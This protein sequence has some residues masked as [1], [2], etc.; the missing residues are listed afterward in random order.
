M[1]AKFRHKFRVTNRLRENFEGWA[2]MLPWILGTLLFFIVPI[3]QSF[4][5]S[6]GDLVR[7]VD[8]EVEFVG[9]V[10][11]RRIL[12]HDMSIVPGIISLAYY[13]LMNLPIV[14]V[15]SLFTA[16]L[17]NTDVKLR[18][19]WRACFILPVV[20][21]TGFVMNQLLGQNVVSGVEGATMELE[22]N[23][24]LTRGLAL[25]DEILLYLGPTV[26]RYITTFL[27]M[28]TS[29]LWRSG[30]QILLFLGGLQSI[31]K[32]LYES[33]HC[34]GATGWESF[35]YITFPML[36]PVTM[37]N[38]IYTIVDYFMDSNNPMVQFIMHLGFET[39][40]FEY[41]AAISVLYLLV[42]LLFVGLIF[43]IFR[44][45]QRAINA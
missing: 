6:V 5:L 29:T 19:F 4:Y 20:L 7:M 28:L 38:I 18:G 12:F 31:N 21:G 27:S 43:L 37:L 23:P 44:L 24:A 33:A 10:H 1:T 11:Y 9:L 42:V 35:W 39:R 32:S 2:L 36:M 16:M 3:F 41:A 22:A 40:Q 45:A 25:S 17:L 34:D 14:I 8:F 13:M 26:T 15:F 30:V